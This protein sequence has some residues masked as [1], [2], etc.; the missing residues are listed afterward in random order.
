[1]TFGHSVLLFLL[2]LSQTKPSD[3]SLRVERA[4]LSSGVTQGQ[5]TYIHFI[6]HKNNNIII[7]IRQ[8]KI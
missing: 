8:K 2:G 6:H 4:Q 7:T 5:D 1:M 3:N